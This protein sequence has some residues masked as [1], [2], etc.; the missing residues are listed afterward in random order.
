MAWNDVKVSRLAASLSFYALLS[1]V[2]LLITFHAIFSLLIDQGT[3]SSGVDHEM[4][5]FLGQQQA[6]ALRAMVDQ[7]QAPSVA[8]LHAIVGFILTFVT[9]AGVFIAL[10]DSMDSIWRTPENAK[11]GIFQ[12]V[13][14]YLKP[15]SMV[16]GF[17]FLL[18]ISMLLQ[19]LLSLG[20][21]NFEQGHST[22]ALTLTIGNVI[23]GWLV[24]AALFAAIF[25]WLPTA[26]VA[27]RD[28]W[29]GA[30]I[31]ASLFVIG[32]TLIGLYIGHSDFTG[33]YGAAGPV[34]AIIVW[35]NYSSQILFTGAVFTREHARAAHR[36]RDRT[37][38]SDNVGANSA[39]K[40]DYKVDHSLPSISSLNM[41][42]LGN[43]IRAYLHEATASAQVSDSPQSE[44]HVAEY[45]DAAKNHLVDATEK[46]VAW[47]KKHPV[48]VIAAATVLV[49]VSA[50]LYG[51]IRVHGDS[52]PH[53]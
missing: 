53:E 3:L 30:I 32:R 50:Y 42:L 23:I 31:T 16:L 41:Q 8:S 15:M 18:L 34:I 52:E 19:A 46:I 20:A 6:Q 29:L 36:Y 47:S 17:G 33:T 35:I 27:W 44:T 11:P 40:R 43:R 14:A 24:T 48:Q 21:N 5:A 10:K 37:D 7:A 9:A 49:G 12:W 25:R 38:S 45:L 2:P 26:R 1:L 39:T 4:T 28:V 13:R 22:A 51:A